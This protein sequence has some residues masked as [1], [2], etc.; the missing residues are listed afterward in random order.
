[1]C[2]MSAAGGWGGGVDRSL[3]LPLVTSPADGGRW[4]VVSSLKLSQ[5]E[6]L[7]TSQ[8][9][10]VGRAGKKPS[11]HEPSSAPGGNR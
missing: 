7:T 11:F 2:E 3:F 5:A 10:Q 6:G 9:L 1:M 4:G 8:G